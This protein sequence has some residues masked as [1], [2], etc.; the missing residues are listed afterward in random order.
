MQQRG[1]FSDKK[2]E[3]TQENAAHFAPWP[4]TDLCNTQVHERQF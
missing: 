3:T 1:H 2:H 4:V